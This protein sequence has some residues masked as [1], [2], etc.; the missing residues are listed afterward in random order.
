MKMIIA[1][2]QK[3]RAWRGLC[4][5]CKERSNSVNGGV[6]MCYGCEHEIFYKD[7]EDARMAHIY[8]DDY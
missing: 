5:F 2:T 3:F 8:G 6:K 1:I 7:E 4:A